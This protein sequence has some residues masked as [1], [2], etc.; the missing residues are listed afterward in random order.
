MKKSI[1]I[2]VIFF[3]FAFDLKCQTLDENSLIDKLIKKSDV[4]IK[5]KDFQLAFQKL[6][7]AREVCKSKPCFEKV[8]L[9]FTEL[10]DTIKIVFNTLET[11]KTRTQRALDAAVRA[12]KIAEKAKE[13][14]L[15]ARNQAITAQN[16]YAGIARSGENTGAFMKALDNR[17][18]LALWM[19]LYNA[20]RH[21]ESK[22]SSEEFIKIVNNTKIGLVKKVKPTKS[23]VLCSASSKNGEKIIVGCD[24]ESVVVWNRKID[25]SFTL[26]ERHGNVNSVAFSPDDRFILT[27]NSNGKAYLYDTLTNNVVKTFDEHVAAINAVAFSPNGKYILTGSADSTSKLW[28]IET[29]SVLNTFDGHKGVITSVA[30]S[31]DGKKVVRGSTDSSIVITEIEPF[32]NP[33]KRKQDYI[34]SSKSLTVKK[35]ERQ[36]VVY[37]SVN[38]IEQRFN[39]EIAAVTSVAFSPDGKKIVTGCTDFTAKVWDLHS[40]HFKSFVEHFDVVTAVAFSDDNT[41]ITSSKD[42]R[43]IQWEVE[44]QKMKR[45][46]EEHASAITT[47]SILNNNSEVLTAGGDNKIIIWHLKDDNTLVKDHSNLK[48]SNANCNVDSIVK[49]SPITNIEFVKAISMDCSKIIYVDSEDNYSIKVWDAAHTFDKR[50][51]Y[52]GHTEGKNIIAGAFSKSDSLMVTV[53]QDKTIKL[54]NIKT[55]AIISNFIDTFQKDEIVKV[56]MSDDDGYLKVTSKLGKKAIWNINTDCFECKFNKY[57]TLDLISEGLKLEK[58]DSLVYEIGLKR[59]YQDELDK[60]GSFNAK[61]VDLNS[62]DKSTRKYYATAYGNLAWYSL[63]S[64]NYDTALIQAQEGLRI[65]KNMNYIRMN[66]GHAYLFKGEIKE[67]KEMYSEFI[68]KYDSLDRFTGSIGQD[69]IIDPEE[70]ILLDFED[71]EKSNHL[72]EKNKPDVE[73]IKIWLRR[74]IINDN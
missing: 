54:W 31:P 62:L 49:R 57:S 1:V 72:P 9:E 15:K 41:I 44:T 46:F 70:L 63:I 11:E 20:T 60:I 68:E 65:D 64:K 35:T 25:S 2:L 48:F 10:F 8:E 38:T 58:E 29:Q 59:K 47:I 39:N 23:K 74:R 40:G 12:K 28:N 7:A 34:V 73:R 67:A 5:K 51:K 6:N 19:M 61:K 30:F 13:E 26:N 43:A 14:A 66:L 52:E 22:L 53:S 55:H 45:E 56:A 50:E 24:D 36:N 71:L 32:I 3:L 18:T 16:K 37:D 33:P 17:P 69:S 21:P 27:G 42:K 4:A